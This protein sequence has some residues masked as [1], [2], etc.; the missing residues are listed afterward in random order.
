MSEFRIATLDDYKTLHPDHDYIPPLVTD[1]GHVSAIGTAHGRTIPVIGSTRP[2]IFD[3]SLNPLDGSQVRIYADEADD[4]LAVLLG[5]EYQ[6]QLARCKQIEANYMELSDSDQMGS[7]G[8]TMREE[9]DSEVTL[10]G[11]IRG[12]FAH[13]A[14]ARAQQL[15]NDKAKASGAW[16]ALTDQERTILEQ[17]ADMTSETAP[18]GIVKEMTIPDPT[19]PGHTLTGR[20]GSWGADVDLILNEVDYYPWCEVPPVFS[21]VTITD[22]KGNSYVDDSSKLNLRIIRVDSAEELLE[23]LGELGVISMTVRPAVPVDAIFRPNYAET[24]QARID[25]NLSAAAD[26]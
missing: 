9:F 10:L 25:A 11:M 14:R 26:N 1:D 19:H 8:H 23:D 17:A 6:S 15:V 21:Q 22:T 16:E 5:T 18:V 24:V 20:V 3:V 7:A 13:T 4:V 2:P 12:T